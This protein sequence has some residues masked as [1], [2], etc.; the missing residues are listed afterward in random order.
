M[1]GST[2]SA[3]QTPV[4]VTFAGA[5]QAPLAVGMRPEAQQS[6]PI[7]IRKIGLHSLLL[8]PLGI[9]PAGQQTPVEVTL[10]ARQQ[11]PPAGA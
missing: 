11:A 6:G 2:G 1:D 8:G 5:Q 3:Q 10:P 9:C 7:G 4:V